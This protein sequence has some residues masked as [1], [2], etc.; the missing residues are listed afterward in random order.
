M[1]RPRHLPPVLLAATT[2]LLALATDAGSVPIGPWPTLLGAREA[3]S[4]EVSAA[5]ERVW[6]EPTLSRTV[7][8]PPARVPLEV[9]AA[10]IDAPDVTA[11]AARFRG[12]GNYRVQAL[13]DERYQGDDGEG[14]H[15]I[16]QLLRRQGQRR[17]I[18]SRGE[19]TSPFLGTISGSA[20]TVVDLETR[21]D[22]VTPTLTAYV[23]ID[24]QVAATLAQILAV[25]FGF[26]ADRKLT[27][28]LRVTARV[29]EWA[30]DP[31]GGFCDWLDRARFPEARRD[32]IVAAL[33]AC[34]RARARAER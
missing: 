27:E 17:V 16:S 22:R 4:P 25:S 9:Y 32:L 5:V 33:P 20:L 14:A 31:T 34:A 15:G 28:G 7:A 24:D 29:A 18:L 11:A 8:G 13:G 3:F 19:H 2:V 12:L 23:L 6:H 21:G 30:V 26:L 1:R 10:F